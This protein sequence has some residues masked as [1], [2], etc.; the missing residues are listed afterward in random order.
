MGGLHVLDLA[1]LALVVEF[2]DEQIFAGIDDRFGHHVFEACL[3]DQAND[4]LGLL[5]RRRHRHGAHDVLAGLQRRDRLRGVIG[6]RAVDVDEIHVRIGQY[7]AEIG[8]AGADP[9][10][11][12]NLIQFASGSADKSPRPPLSDVPDRSV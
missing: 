5:D 7:L 11:V 6:N 2:L 12:A 8:V 4:L 1:E 9:E 3:A 10:P